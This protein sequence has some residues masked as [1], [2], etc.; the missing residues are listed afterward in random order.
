MKTKNKIQNL[1]GRQGGDHGE[2]NIQGYPS[3]S[4]REDFYNQYNEQKHINQDAFPGKEESKR[5]NR[6]EPGN[7]NFFKYGIS[8]NDTVIPGSESDDFLGFA[9]SEDEENRFYS[10]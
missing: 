9:I 10:F 5:K 2:I 7:E 6:F 8:G 4:S 3:H 1:P